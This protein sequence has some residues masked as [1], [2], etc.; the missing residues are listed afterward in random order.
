MFYPEGNYCFVSLK[1]TT[2]LYGKGRLSLTL[3]YVTHTQ[4]EWIGRSTQYYDGATHSF[5]ELRSILIERLTYRKRRYDPARLITFI[6][7]SADWDYLN[8]QAKRYNWPNFFTC[9]KSRCQHEICF[10]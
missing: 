10:V 2:T 6:I 7:H 8:E 9:A 3:T 5:N 1:K 4:Q